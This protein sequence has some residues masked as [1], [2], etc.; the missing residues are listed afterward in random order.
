MAPMELLCKILKKRSWAIYERHQQREYKIP[1]PQIR[2]HIMNTIFLI[3]PKTR[4]V[5]S[6]EW[7]GQRANGTDKNGDVKWKRVAGH[8]SLTVLVNQLYQ[9]D[10]RTSGMTELKDFM[11]YAQTRLEAVTRA[12]SPELVVCRTIV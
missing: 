10:L 5:G 7:V 9:E 12:L 3:D 6:K 4:I 1:P 11:N 2:G 8:K